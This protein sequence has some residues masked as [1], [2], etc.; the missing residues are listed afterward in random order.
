MNK[1]RFAASHPI[2]NAA[3]RTGCVRWYFCPMKNGCH[4]EI[5]QYR[6]KQGIYVLMKL[7]K[8]KLFGLKFRKAI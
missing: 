3:A 5:Q 6:G 7:V 4:Y 2:I 8:K 1:H